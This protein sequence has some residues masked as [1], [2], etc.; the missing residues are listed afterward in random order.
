MKIVFDNI[1]FSLQKAGGISSLFYEIINKIVN[2]KDVDC[3]F[4]EYEDNKKNI[5]RNILKIDKD[6]IINQNRKFKET[7]ISRY[8]NVYI[9]K[10]KDQHFIFHSTY[11]RTS[12]NKR[13]I[14]ITTVHDFTYEY[15]A[16][17][18]K[19]RL[20]S[21][22]KFNAIRNSDYVICVSESTKKDLKRFIKDY[23][24][25][26]IFVIPNGVSEDYYQSS[27][28]KNNSSVLN[29]YVLY[30]GS[31]AQYKNFE[32]V[33]DL[34]S[35][36]EYSLVVVGAKLK[37]EEKVFLN[38]KLGAHRFKCFVNVSNKELNILYN[39]AFAFLYPSSYEGFG[40]PVLES[41]LAGCP[42]IA[43]NSSSIPEVIGDK[44]LLLNSLEVN[45]GLKMFAMLEDNSFRSQII[46]K[47]L[48]NA[49]KYS[50]NKTFH[51]YMEL[52]R[53][54]YNSIKF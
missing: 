21:W 33:V 19:K 50:W 35:N 27:D 12:K 14:N 28:L 6:L 29:K 48:E 42:V 23:P 49:E 51:S 9:K 25:E 7:R 5:L 53:L 39:N 34:L 40:I 45:E 11:Y 4:L 1:I 52:Y 2:I 31:R 26:K 16:K 46:K 13:A 24:E 22:Q 17:G 54:A 10:F 32:Y 44:T 3:Y 30:V 38:N 8:M 15:F 37:E 36:T 18:I 43:Y 20:H 47:G 41:Q